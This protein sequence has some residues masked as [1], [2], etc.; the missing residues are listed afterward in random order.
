M[1][2]LLK[3]LGPNHFVS[4]KACL[5]CWETTNHYVGKLP[6]TTSTISHALGHMVV[7]VYSYIFL[8]MPAC[9]IQRATWVYAWMPRVIFRFNHDIVRTRKASDCLKPHTCT[10]PSVY[11]RHHNHSGHALNL[12]G[13]TTTLRSGDKS[14]PES[15]VSKG[16]VVIMRCRRR[17]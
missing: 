8:H 4:V 14:A 1:L 13:L 3:T 5:W 12:S 11:E 7:T 6:I 17:P 16:L 9:Q 10:W 2:W 15:P